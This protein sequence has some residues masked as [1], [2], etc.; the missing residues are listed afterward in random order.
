MLMAWKSTAQSR[1]VQVSTTSQVLVLDHKDALLQSQ[2]LRPQ[3]HLLLPLIMLK[4]FS[5]LHHLLEDHLNS[6]VLIQK[7]MNQ[8]PVISHI[9]EELGL[10]DI[11]FSIIVMDSMIRLKYMISQVLSL[12][13]LT[14]V[15]L[16]SLITKV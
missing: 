12:E 4:T 3:Q 6:S 7:D 10:L 15:K 16:F 14:M 8:K 11:T 13:A 2:L 1:E 9:G 5:Y